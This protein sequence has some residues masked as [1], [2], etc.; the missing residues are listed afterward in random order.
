M[1]NKKFKT[2]TITEDDFAN[3]VAFVMHDAATGANEFDAE[4]RLAY[5]LGGMH[6]AARVQNR[7]FGKEDSNGEGKSDSFIQGKD[8][9][10]C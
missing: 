5:I 1:G 6:F 3:A 10:G 9:R 7:L 2:I 4:E 8:Y